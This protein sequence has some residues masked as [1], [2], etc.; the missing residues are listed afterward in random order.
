MIASCRLFMVYTYCVVQVLLF[1]VAKGS[2]RITYGGYDYPDWA[3]A[4]GWSSAAV[5][6]VW[7]P[8]YMIF[9]LCQRDKYQ[10]A[11]KDA[12]HQFESDGPRTVSAFDAKFVHISI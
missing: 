9:R 4:L 1:L 6:M 12:E 10:V 5:S 8:L 3:V 11:G 2:T 7:M